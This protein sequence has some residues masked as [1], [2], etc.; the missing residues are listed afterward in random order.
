MKTVWIRRHFELPVGLSEKSEKRMNAVEELGY[1][2]KYE[3]VGDNETAVFCVRNAGSTWDTVVYKVV[4]APGI[5]NALQ[6]VINEAYE[7]LYGEEND[8][9]S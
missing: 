7:I 1:V 8:Q 5:G 4:S 9:E 2:F 3:P 6:L